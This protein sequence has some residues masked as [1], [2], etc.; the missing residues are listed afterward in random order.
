MAG[1][2]RNS[3]LHMTA[4][5]EGGGGGR[6]GGGGGELTLTLSSVTTILWVS[7]QPAAKGRNED[8]SYGRGSS[9]KQLCAGRR[10][11]TGTPTC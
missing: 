10:S 3:S 6:G 7:F 9:I 11:H 1:R 8:E 4:G 2:R 5:E